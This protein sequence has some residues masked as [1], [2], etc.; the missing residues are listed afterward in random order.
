MPF[1]L[2]LVCTQMQMSPAEA[3]SAATINGAWGLNL[4][5]R[6]GSIEPGKDA[7]MAVFDVAD[8]REIAYWVAANRCTH[9]VL[10]GQSQQNG[11]TK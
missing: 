10:N 8:Y 7:D 5:E 6:K 9:T 11:L 2:S 4:Q 1:V 3:I